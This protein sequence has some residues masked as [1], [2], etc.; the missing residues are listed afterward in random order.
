MDH[1]DLERPQHQG[2]NAKDSSKDLIKI[3]E[4]IKVPDD[5][6]ESIRIFSQSEL[7]FSPN[8]SLF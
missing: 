3:T 2:Q 6:N 1:I 8:L 4:N 5:S 7:F